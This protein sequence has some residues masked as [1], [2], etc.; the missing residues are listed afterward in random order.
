MGAGGLQA[1]T[2]A[3]AEKIRHQRA[4]GQQAT[5]LEGPPH[6]SMWGEEESVSLIT[7]FRKQILKS[8]LTISDEKL[9]LPTEMS[10]HCTQ[11]LF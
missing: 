5:A 3:T 6:K 9:H 10:Q 7:V 11:C 2:A 1:R 4:A 8:H